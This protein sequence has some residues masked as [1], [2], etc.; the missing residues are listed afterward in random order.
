[1]TEKRILHLTL[2][3]KWFDEIATG[4]KTEEYR[5]ARAYWS[6]RLYPHGSRKDFD[7]VW[8]TNGYGKDR[9]FMRVVYLYTSYRDK[10]N[11]FVIKFGK[12]LE[13]RNWPGVKAV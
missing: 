1:M 5:T 12:V 8:F 10:E 9:P 11:D 6:T 3:R 2:Y 7:E 4:K 13:I